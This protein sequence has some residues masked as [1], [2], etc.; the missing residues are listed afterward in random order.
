MNPE[1]DFTKLLKF[2]FDEGVIRLGKD[3]MIL[4]PADAFC[5]LRREL[6]DTLG[7]DLARGVL[8]RFGYRCGARDVLNVRNLVDFDSDA[9]WM[10]S[11]P[12]LHTLEGVVRVDSEL[13][14]YDRQKG[15]FLMRGVWKNSYEA[16]NHLQLYGISQEPVCWTLTGYASGF[17]SGFMGSRVICVETMCRGMGDPVCVFE[18]RTVDEW[19][20]VE[21]A[22]RVID[23]LEPN[24]S[25]KSL[26][27][28]LI[29]ERERA[30]QWR[31][32][33]EAALDISTNLD[34]SELP[35]KLVFHARS[36]LLCDY[37][38]L[39]IASE[40]GDRLIVY[41]SSREGMVH[42]HWWDE[43]KG[44]VADIFKTRRP[45]LVN[46]RRR[47]WSLGHEFT[48]LIGVP[49]YAKSDLVGAIVVANKRDGFF[50]E[51]DLE[52]LLIL[53]AQASTA[54]ENARLYEKTDEKLQQKVAELSRLNDV[55]TA[56]HAELKKSLSIHNQLTALVLDE[57]GLDAI[58]QNLAQM[59]NNPVLV[60]D[61]FFNIISIFDDAN[62]DNYQLFK[63]LCSVLQQEE[64]KRTLWRL[65]E[66][67]SIFR[68]Q[69]S[70]AAGRGNLVAVPV[71]AAQELLGIVATVEGDKKLTELDRIALEHAGTVVAL[72]F[73]KQKAAFDMELRLK[74]EL[75]ED[76][77]SQRYDTEEKIFHRALKLGLDPQKN[78]RAM[79]VR[80]D[81]VEGGEEE[82]SASKLEVFKQVLDITNSVLRKNAP[83][84]VLVG[85]GKDVLILIPRPH[86]RIDGSKIKRGIEQVYDLAR[87]LRDEIASQ[88]PCCSVWIGIGNR[89]NKLT[90]FNRSYEEAKATVEII[91]ALNHSERIMAYDHLGVFGILEINKD[92][93]IE[94][95]RRVIGPLIDYDVKH[96]T[97]LVSTLELYFKN[98]CNLQK[99][100]RNGFMCASTMKYRLKRIREIAGIDLDDPE[101][102]LQVQLALR[103]RSGLF[104]KN[105]LSRPVIR[106]AREA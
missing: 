42:V 95:C 82:E 78:Y 21:R 71:V 35:R 98:N 16:E 77:V 67:R 7:M 17:G 32:M 11:G 99:A 45:L 22:R 72:E 15:N 41:Q 19:K 92:R 2:N 85:K 5:Q 64:T 9:D 25:V 68:Y 24:V 40:Q 58:T 38:L 31:A 62:S 97:Q 90:E 52:L 93:F 47:D 46:E 75:L 91:K 94:F 12:L 4:L 60:A 66:N 53:G 26:E 104:K 33:S 28:M 74:E 13:L 59:I 3:R 10:L 23:D 27:K 88:L 56:Q 36:L 69:L 106:R 29:E 105:D 30:I 61:R 86:D 14:E 83:D 48:G 103:L 49:L 96:R 55:L 51:A 65:M 6:I 39:A 44:A 8:R 84:C 101:V 37:A 100:A 54:L 50:S 57:R 20:G 76:I 102:N 34:S 70:G 1:L 18:M 80:V 81:R 43:P 73:L 87:L 79:L 63:L 89:C